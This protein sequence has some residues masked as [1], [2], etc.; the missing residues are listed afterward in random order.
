MILT[1]LKF[2]TLKLLL[3][4]SHLRRRLTGDGGQL[5]ALEQGLVWTGHYGSGWGGIVNVNQNGLQ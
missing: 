2:S 5:D 4:A 3:H 1:L